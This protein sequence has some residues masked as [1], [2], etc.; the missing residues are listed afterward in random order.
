MS[1]EIKSD[2]FTLKRNCNGVT[3]TVS[4]SGFYSANTSD[5]FKTNAETIQ[6]TAN[7]RNVDIKGNSQETCYTRGVTCEADIKVV[8]NPNQFDPKYH[9]K[10]QRAQAELAGL[11]VQS[12][13]DA[14]S[15]KPPLIPSFDFSKVVKAIT[16]AFSS[17]NPPPMPNIKSEHDVPP[18]FAE[19]IKWKTECYTADAGYRA[20]KAA[21]LEAESQYMQYVENQKAAAND[22]IER[23]E[24]LF[25]SGS[26]ATEDRKKDAKP[27]IDRKTLFQTIPFQHITEIEKHL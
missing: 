27:N 22:I 25:D 11:L 17:E 14:K 6:E 20:L 5:V 1:E 15:V 12:G 26:P 16:S 4:S 24:N 19:F 21:A 3:E 13:D 8:G 7:Q 10:L 23:F 9:N 2:G 18:F